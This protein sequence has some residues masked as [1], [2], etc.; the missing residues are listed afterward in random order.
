MATARDIIRKGLRLINVP[1][2]GALLSQA[3][4]AAGLDTLQDIIRSNSV[5]ESFVPGIHRHFFP[6]TPQRAIYRYG[7]GVLLPDF[8][9]RLFGSAVPIRIED[10][11]IREGATIID[12]RLV[13]NGGFDGATGWTPSAPTWVIEN[14]VARFVPGVAAAALT[15]A[16]NP[17]LSLDT[18]YTL[19]LEA[20]MN[21][22][23]IQVEVTSTPGGLVALQATIST[24]G[25]YSFPFFPEEAG[26]H[27]VRVLTT[28]TADA[29]T[30]D[31]VGLIRTGAETLEL[32][33]GSDYTVEIVDQ[34]VYNR[35]FTKGTGGRPYEILFSRNFPVGEIRFDN[36]G[37]AGDILVMDV[38]PS[39]ELPTLDT[40]V[41]LHPDAETWLKFR[42]AYEIAGEYGK[43][44]SPDQVS[45]MRDAYN[46]MTAGN[47]RMV[48]LRVDR[49]IAP[50]PTFDINRGDP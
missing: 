34:L 6:L 23:V 29:G 33:R 2:R 45:I 24:S 14:G 10:A 22:G 44:L 5:S 32:T 38:L 30:I 12:N 18:Q 40:E 48:H 46:S 47:D 43:A 39:L 41:P 35:R 25:A 13:A 4:A 3:D 19:T 28:T 17:Q 31:N 27:V 37:V 11:Y 36:A 16:S 8:D 49:A 21:A 42:L 15:V 26:D 50:R 20:S 9:S 1:G 7:P